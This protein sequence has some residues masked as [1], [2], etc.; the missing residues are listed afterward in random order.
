MTLLNSK[1]AWI[2]GIALIAAVAGT[3]SGQRRG[4][5][6]YTTGKEI[7]EHVCQGCHMPDAKGAVGAGFY[8][9]LAGNRKLSFAGYPILVMLR[10]Q[11]AMPSFADLTDAQIAETT[12]YIRT[13]F[14]NQFPGMAT[15]EQVQKLRPQQVQREAQRPG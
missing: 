4:G 15:P 13:N 9:P 6:S 14:G 8:P 10:G 5:Y 7:Y 3:A 2:G 1:V 11:K 12:N